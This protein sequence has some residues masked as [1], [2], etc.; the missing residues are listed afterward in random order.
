[1]VHGMNGVICPTL[2]S[3]NS[4][5]PHALSRII[6]P[7]WSVMMTLSAGDGQRYAAW[8]FV[9]RDVLRLFENEA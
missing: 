1:M 5:D 7:S 2:R 4:L 3:K 8:V 9:K 6:T